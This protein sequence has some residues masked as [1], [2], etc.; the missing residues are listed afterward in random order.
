MALTTKLREFFE[1]INSKKW[2]EIS[3]TLNR[4]EDM[5]ATVNSYCVQCGNCCNNRCGNKFI[6]GSKTFCALHP[7]IGEDYPGGKTIAS[8]DD[9]YSKLDL[10]D[11][12]KPLVCHSYGPHT[13][14]SALIHYSEE[15]NYELF[16]NAACHCSGA[17]NLF[18]EY[19]VFANKD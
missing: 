11:F 15:G 19:I 12:V 2:P 1:L 17:S 9:I 6:E 3:S 8:Y 10:T 5:L 4:D 18:K 14:L 13:V 7:A 16:N